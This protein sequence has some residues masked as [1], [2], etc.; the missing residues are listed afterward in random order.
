MSALPSPSPPCELGVG[1]SV[2]RALGDRVKNRQRSPTSLLSFW[3]DFVGDDAGS[4]GSAPLFSKPEREP[5]I[6]PPGHRVETERSRSFCC[7]RGGPGEQ[8]AL[9][10]SVACGT[11]RPSCQQV[12]PT[13][14]RCFRDGAGGSGR[15][16][17]HGVL[18]PA[19][20]LKVAL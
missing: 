10:V 18:S 14:P 16:P 12:V 11:L 3:K 20:H 6:I 8:S 13:L 15:N 19:A 2:T 1:R 9:V 17:R 4:T 7:S 5:E